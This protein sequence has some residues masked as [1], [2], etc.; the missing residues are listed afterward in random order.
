MTA[1]E[2]D[3][4]TKELIAQGNRL[5]Q[6]LVDISVYSNGS[7]PYES[8]LQMPVKRLR[9]IENSIADKIKKDKGVKESEML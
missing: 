2:L 5:E 3:A 6:N 1:Q 9:Q 8:L 4:Y 7:F